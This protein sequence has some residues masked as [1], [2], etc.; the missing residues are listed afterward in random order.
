MY[1]SQVQLRSDAR[2]RRQY[3]KLIQESYQFHSLVWDLFG[4]DPDQSRDFLFRV[5]TSKKLP[6]FL[7]VSAREP[8]NRY[9]V[10]DIQT[11]PYHPCFTV[12]QRL[13][14]VL[15][16][17]PVRKKRDDQKKQHRHDV[18][19]EV[20]SRLK[21]DGIPC[22]EWPKES[23]IVQQAGFV[24]LASRAESCGFHVAEH[25]VICDGY[26]QNRFR[27]P[28]GNHDIRFSTVEFNGLLTVTDPSALMSTLFYGI[29]PEKGFG[30]GLLLVKSARV[31][32]DAP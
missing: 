2:D 27:K 12:G 15:R 13:S 11:K 1:I 26:L 19:M 6:T 5:D 29:G 4:E 8:V 23:E 14:F 24:W 28:K 31:G 32:N 18:V 17:N 16:A 3:W 9:D 7:V 25:E 20:K 22:F 21:E 30:C 10:W